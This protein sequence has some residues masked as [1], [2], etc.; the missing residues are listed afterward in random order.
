[1]SKARTTKKNYYQD[2]SGQWWY[3]SPGRKMRA[4]A[5]LYK[6]SREGCDGENLQ[7]VTLAKSQG[8]VFCSRRC[9]GKYGASKE[10]RAGVS[11]H[12]WKGGRR[13]NNGY[14]SIYAPDHP[15]RDART[16]V[17]EHRLVMEAYLGRY[18]TRLEKVHH[19]NGVKTDNRIENLELW[20]GSHPHGQR[21]IDL[22]AWARSIIQQYEG[23]EAKLAA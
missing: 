4:K 19:K 7:Q 14:V 13:K 15:N 10:D 3:Q 23:D 18:L 8:R 5:G 2:D 1:M 20:S 6:C 16:S 17:L 9:A 12:R 11:C 21:A 22:L